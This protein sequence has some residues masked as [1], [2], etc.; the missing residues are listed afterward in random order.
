MSNFM[1][2]PFN[3]LLLLLLLHANVT[4]RYI[5]LLVTLGDVCGKQRDFSSCCSAVLSCLTANTNSKAS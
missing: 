2:S 1:L 5:R 4:Q 3:Q